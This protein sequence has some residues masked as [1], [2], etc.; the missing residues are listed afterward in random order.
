MKATLLSYQLVLLVHLMIYITDF[1][2]H[3]TEKMP[4]MLQI[5]SEQSQNQFFI[6]IGKST[7][8]VYI[9]LE[10]RVIIRNV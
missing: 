2:F 6:Y 7:E 4:N 9:T 5:L 8:S 3:L 10:Q 1:H